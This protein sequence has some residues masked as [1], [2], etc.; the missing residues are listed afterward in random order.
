MAKQKSILSFE[1]KLKRLEEITEILESDQTSLEDSIKLFEESVQLSKEC[2]S[3]LEN[4]ELK[5]KNL[6]NEMNE[7]SIKD[8]KNY[9]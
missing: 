2:I 9:D 5:I 8:F 7:L 1:A 4:A 3:I 6:K